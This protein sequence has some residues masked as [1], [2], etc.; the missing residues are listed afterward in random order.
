M[1]THDAVAPTAQAQT[2]AEALEQMATGV[3]ALHA[4]QNTGAL[5][6]LRRQNVDCPTAPAFHALLAASAPDH[7]FA[8]KGGLDDAMRRFARI[9]QFMA[10]APDKLKARPLG[11][12][13]QAI[14]YPDMRLAMLLNAQGATLASLVRRA[15]RRI[16]LSAEPM[17]YRD[18][19]QLILYAG[20]SDKTKQLDDLRLKVARDFRRAARD[21]DKSP[22]AD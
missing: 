21:A 2:P 14:G 6:A 11:G 13:L 17:P 19:G 5:A 18:L 10:F 4:K 15:A 8:A 12:V 3:Y 20:R 7:L 22:Q 1:S 16:A 9:A